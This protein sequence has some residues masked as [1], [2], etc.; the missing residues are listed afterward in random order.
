MTQ[1]KL[2]DY[3][4]FYDQFDVAWLDGHFSGSFADGINACIECVDRHTGEGR[5]ALYW[6]GMDG[7]SGTVTFEELHAQ[8]ARFANL[9]TS[10]GMGPGDRIAGLLPRTPDLLTVIFG[11]LRAGAVY[12]P[13]F[14]AFG[15]KAIQQRVQGSGAKVI[16]TDSANRPKLDNVEACPLALVSGATET[17]DVDLHAALSQQTDTFEPVMRHG[18][19]LCLMMFTSGTT[20]A[21]KGVNVPL[22][23][24][25]ENW[26]YM[27]YGLGL[28]PEETFWNIAD[29]GWAYGL[30]HA[31]IGPLLLGH[32]TT[33]Q[34]AP[35]SVDGRL[36]TMLKHEITN[37][38]GAPTAYRMLIASG[39]KVPNQLRGRLRVASSAGERLNPEVVRWFADELDCPLKEQYLSLIH[40]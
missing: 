14:I 30:Y 11:T 38:A 8:S 10:L 16:V 6:E 7:T 25:R 22:T 40:I 1:P 9:L 29:P 24:L 33:F 12:Q 35:F 19:D 17:D 39:D 15:P 21:P 32:A 31:V 27:T 18:D 34:E 3:Q 26:M 20:G 28:R 2:D 5:I 23:S 13:L 4:T 37:L 36:E